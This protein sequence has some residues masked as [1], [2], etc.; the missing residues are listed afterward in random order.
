MSGHDSLIE[1]PRAHLE[2]DRLE[3]RDLAEQVLRIDDDAV[4]DE[5]GHALAHDAR[6]NELQRRL[7]A[8]DDERVPGVVAALETDDGL[9]VVGEPVDDLAL[10]FVAPLRADDDDVA[11][12]CHAHRLASTRTE[13]RLKLT[14][15]HRSW[16]VHWPRRAISDRSNLK[17]LSSP[18]SPE[19]WRTTISPRARKASTAS[20]SLAS[21]LQGA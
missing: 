12:G 16:T 17:P 5:A 8:A 2:A 4:A 13:A 20:R 3:P 6:G 10:A 18:A 14:R 21:S 7:D 1:Q 11:S 19:A 9:G 15:H